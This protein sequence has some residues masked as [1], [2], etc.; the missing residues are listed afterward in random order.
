MPYPKKAVGN[1]D[2]EN[3]VSNTTVETQNECRD[4]CCST[5]QCEMAVFHDNI[6]EE[7]CVLYHCEL[8]CEEIEKNSTVLLVKKVKGK[9]PI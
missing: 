3:V 9:S 7:N 4:V 8:G 1:T 2:K 5:T 6:Q